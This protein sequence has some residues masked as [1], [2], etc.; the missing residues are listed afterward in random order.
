MNNGLYAFAGAF[1]TA[2]EE[3]KAN[4]LLSPIINSNTL[5]SSD[6]IYTSETP[7]AELERLKGNK[8]NTSS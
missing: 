6:V 7:Y 2:S 4:L 1:D 5:F 8:I 3:A